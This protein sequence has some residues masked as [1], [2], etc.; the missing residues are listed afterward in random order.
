M[1]QVMPSASKAEVPVEMVEAEE[2]ADPP[3][4]RAGVSG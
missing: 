2:P 4:E 1:L 3:R